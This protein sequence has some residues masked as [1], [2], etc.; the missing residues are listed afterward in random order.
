MHYSPRIHDAVE[1]AIKVHETDGKQKRKG[2]DI[3]YITHPLTVGLILARVGADED[4]VIAGILH[5]TLEDSVADHKVTR[6]MLEKQF[7]MEVARLVA[8][9]TEHDKA[10]SWKARK[11]AAIEHIRHCSHDELLV[12]SADLISNLSEIVRDVER[13]GVNTLMRFNA[14]EPKKENIIWHYTEAIRAIT[15]TWPENPLLPELQGF[16]TTLQQH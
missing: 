5:D 13:E 12:K 11:E 6:D 8:A 15:D 9:V 14:P 1:L 16:V 10:L 3:P 2:K 4:V 7:G